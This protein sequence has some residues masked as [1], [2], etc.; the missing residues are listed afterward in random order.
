M[1]CTLQDSQ[2][3]SEAL[4]GRIYLD[5]YDFQRATEHLKRALE[6]S[7]ENAT[8]MLLLGQSLAQSGQFE[9]GRALLARGQS[10]LGDTDP[11]LSFNAEQ[12][13]AEVEL[14][15]EHDQVRQRTGQGPEVLELT[16]YAPH[17]VARTWLRKGYNQ[18]A[19]QLFADV[20]ESPAELTSPGFYDQ[21]AI[22]ACE[23]FL[24]RGEEAYP[25]TDAE[26]ADWLENACTWLD[27]E[28]GLLEHYYDFGLMDA[29]VVRGRLH[30][31]TQ[32]PALRCVREEQ[33]YPSDESRMAW[34]LLWERHESLLDELGSGWNEN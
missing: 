10:L 14:D 34:R 11:E 3:V 7:P 22:A 23:V 12:W 33:R 21:A 9:E 31:M 2:L 32:A 1:P 4:Q 18:A 29:V 8:L 30:I 28:L 5:V 15:L 24:G 27:A 25:L 6:I 20:I 19:A 13:I 16:G 26:R 17:A